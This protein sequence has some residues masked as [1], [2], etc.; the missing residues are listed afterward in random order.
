MPTIVAQHQESK[1]GIVILEKPM[2]WKDA[3][4]SPSESN[5]RG[6]EVLW[7]SDNPCGCLLDIREEPVS[8][9]CSSLPVI[10]FEGRS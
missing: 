1:S 5:R 7:V 9:H 8:E 2:V 3:Q 4:L 6:M 10:V